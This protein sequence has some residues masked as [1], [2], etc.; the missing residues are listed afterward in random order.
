MSIS[1]RTWSSSTQNGTDRLAGVVQR[2]HSRLR[3]LDGCFRAE[4]QAVINGREHILRRDRIG[5]DV[6]G[7][8]VSATMNGSAANPRTGEQSR[9]TR[10]PMIASAMLIDPRR[11]AHFGQDHDQR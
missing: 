11:L 4:A 9:V 1:L 6:G 5:R 7:D 10:D 2:E 3:V 8:L